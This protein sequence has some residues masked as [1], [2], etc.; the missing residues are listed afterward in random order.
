MEPLNLVDLDR[1]ATEFDDDVASTPDVDG[2]CSST[3][4]TLPAAHAL[5]QPRQPWLFRGHAGWVAMM[6]GHHPEGWHYIE[7]LEA[8]WGLACPLA[9]R[10]GK[11]VSA[12][13]VDL[14][15]Q[16]SDDWDVLILSGLP[17]GSQLLYHLVVRLLRHYELLQGQV[18]TRHV[19][20]L[21]GGVDGFLG[22]RSR[23]F[24]KALRRSLRAA[25][26]TGIEFAPLPQPDDT[27]AARALYRRLQRI[28]ATSWK[29]RVGVGI[30]SG[31]MATFYQHMVPRLAK[32]RA[33]R[34]LVARHQGRDVAYVLG[35]IFGATY[36]GLQFSFDD[37]YTRLSLGNLCQYHQI[38]ALCQE[39]ITRYDLGTGMEYK[40][41]WAE[42]THDSIALIARKR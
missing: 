22:R 28:E 27:A 29:G 8:M 7:P 20:C 18:T 13:F 36:R 38:A 4:W 3:L 33:L 5:M 10:D 14:C 11:A 31:A 19:A 23:N 37:D 34:A 17:T 12:E 2:F 40:R 21:H 16:R 35:G 25:R 30:D 26:D 15:R 41:R 42:A 39:G 6:R 1:L 9:G 24:R 32:R